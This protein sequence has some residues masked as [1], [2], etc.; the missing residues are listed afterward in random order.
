[1]SMTREEALARLEYTV[2]Y[3]CPEA[4]GDN[5]GDCNYC[6]YYKNFGGCLN[7]KALLTLAKEGEENEHE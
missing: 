5:I 1:M 6:S 4:N 3:H 7:M 2:R